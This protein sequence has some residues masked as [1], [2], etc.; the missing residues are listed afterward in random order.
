AAVVESTIVCGRVVSGLCTFFLLRKCAF[1]R[2]SDGSSFLVTTDRV[3]ARF[4]DQQLTYKFVVKTTT[5]QL[6]LHQ[7]C[8][9]CFAVERRFRIYFKHFQVEERITQSIGR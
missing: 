7:N 5:L 2:S 8:C 9:F 3:F 1:I 6:H 4:W